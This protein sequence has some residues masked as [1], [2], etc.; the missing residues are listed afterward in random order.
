[1]ERRNMRAGGSLIA[2]GTIVGTISGGLLG[3]PSAGLLVGFGL[4]VLSALIVWAIDHKRQN[5]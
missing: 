5:R 2:V 4:G 3:Q 1:M